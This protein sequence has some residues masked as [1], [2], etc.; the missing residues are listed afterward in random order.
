MFHKLLIANRGE[1]AVRL[2]RACQELGIIAAAVYADADRHALH[3]REA[4]EAYHIGPTP[5]AESY[6]DI[7]RVLDA[8][9]RAGAD[10]VHPGYGFLSEN[11][12]FAQA[13]VDAGLTFIGPTPQQIRLMGCKERAR[14]IAEQNGLPVAKADSGP[15]SS[16]EALRAAGAR[17]GYPLL[18]KA[19]SGGGGRGMRRVAGEQDLSEAV[20]AA[21]SEAAHAFGDDRVLLERLLVGARHVEVQILADRFG[22]VASLGCRDC[23]VQRRHQKVIEEAPAPGLSEALTR[24]LEDGSCGLARAIGYENAGTIEWLVA[25]DGTLAFLEMNTRLQVEHPVTEAVMGV[26]LVKAQLLLAAGARL[27]EV[28]TPTAP[29]G[30]AIECRLYA[31]DPQQSFLPSPGKLAVFRGLEGSDLRVDTGFVEGDTL[32]DAYDPLI[33][34]LIVFGADR[35]DARTK[36]LRALSRLAILGV[37]TNV[38]LLRRILEHDDFIQKPVHTTWLEERLGFLLEP[39]AAGLPALFAAAAALMRPQGDATPPTAA[40]SLNPWSQLGSWTNT[41]TEVK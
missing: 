18:V 8:A 25:P 26:D 2:V 35:D 27:A 23:S 19:T 34:K 28:Y 17:V 1:I 7:A 41:E 33:A 24:K 6:L 20:S 10:A 32:S 37:H 36:L 15:W 39:E 40:P 9:K 4:D 12:A 16:P 13:V 38:G 31:E 22:D 29:R 5:P 21:R 3:V 14:G 30:H 11:H